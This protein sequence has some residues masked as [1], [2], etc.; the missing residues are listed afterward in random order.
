MNHI[1]DVPPQFYLV[2][3]VDILSVDE[4]GSGI[5]LQKAVDHFHGRGLAAAGRP[6]QDDELPVRDGEVQVLE[7][8][9]LS[10]AFG[11]VLELDH[12]AHSFT[13]T[14]RLA[15]SAAVELPTRT[16]TSPA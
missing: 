5:R 9:G 1:S 11:D 7:N 8:G 12:I 14:K 16:M 13:V 4:D 6:D 10:I 2:L 15:A 3:T